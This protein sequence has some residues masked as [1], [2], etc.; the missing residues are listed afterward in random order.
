MPATYVDQVQKLDIRSMMAAAFKAR[1]SDHYIVYWVGSGWHPAA[2]DRAVPS[3]SGL[4]A[5][6][7]LDRPPAKGGPPPS[8]GQV[9]LRF[10]QPDG[11]KCEQTLWLTAVP[12]RNHRSRWKTFCPYSREPAQI[13][14]LSLSAQ[15]FVSRQVAGLKYR[16]KLRK[17]RNCRARMFAIMRELEALH[18]GPA[19]PKPI[20]MAEALYQD[21]MQEL[22]EMDIRW[23]C[24]ALKR[25]QPRF[26]GEPFDYAN[27]T[28]ERVNYPPSTVLFYAKKGVRQLKA[29]YRKRYGLPAAAA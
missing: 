4:V 26:W 9:F 17:V 6:I 24:A 18:R 23:M 15:Q 10:L 28:P 7:D 3:G 11:V 5:Y 12:T 19:I 2:D 14:Y 1:P 21:L 25:P 13:L 8:C 29:K 27:A 22:V 16:R 20:R